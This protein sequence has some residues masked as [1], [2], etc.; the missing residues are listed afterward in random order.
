MSFKKSEKKVLSEIYRRLNYFHNGNVDTKLLM[1]ALPSEIK[2]IKH[3]G[4]VK[5]SSTEIARNL[6]WYCLTEKG[7]SFFSNYTK[8]YLSEKINEKLFNN[9]II[10]NFD[11]NLL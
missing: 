6:N 4:L 9:E 1:L 3:L 11:Y 5:A 10:I 8:P 2:V 7:K